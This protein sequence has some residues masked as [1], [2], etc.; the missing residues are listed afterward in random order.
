MPEIGASSQSLRHGEFNLAW[1]LALGRELAREGYDAA[2][3]LPNSWKSAL[4]PFFA[5]IPAAHRLHRRSALPAAQPHPPLDARLPQLA[6]RYALLAEDSRHSGDDAG[7][8][9]PEPHLAG[10]IPN[11]VRATLPRSACRRA[12]AGRVLPRRRIRPGQALAGAPLRRTGAP[13]CRSRPT[14]RSGCSARPRMRR[15]RRN[16]TAVRRRRHQPV[17]PTDARAG[18]RPAL[19]RALVVSNDSGLMHVAAALDR[20]L[21]A[22]YGSS[23]PTYTPPLSPRARLI[24]L[25]P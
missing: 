12:G 6:Q 23:S 5:G 7:Q 2:I 18:H 20:P 22:L 17:R 25:K 19:L 13:S 16:R 4:L 15:R 9:L 8:P 14:F 3:V 21:V 1:P 11:S 24:S 10:R